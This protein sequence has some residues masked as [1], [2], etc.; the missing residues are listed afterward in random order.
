LFHA[1]ISHG[2]ASA[3]I[4]MTAKPKSRA[5][6]WWGALVR[7]LGLLARPVRRAQGEGGVVIEPYRGYGSRS[8]IFMIGRVF[9]QSA[10]EREAEPDDLAA[11]LR[12][13]GRRIRRRKVAR[14]D[15]SVRFSG[16][17]SRVRTDKDGYFRV[18]LTPSDPPD[19]DQ[20][21]HPVELEL[22]AE[23][24]V[25]ARGL[26]FIPPASCRFVVVSDIDD[27]VMYTGVANKLAMLW[28]LFVADAGSR[29][30]FPGVAALYRAFHTGVG[31][32]ER[33][34]ILY[35]SRAPWGIY[36]VL[37]TFFR[38]NAIP[39]GP[40]L[41]LREWGLSWRK[42]WPRRA[43]DHKRDLIE[44]MLALYPHLPFVLIGDSG[45]HD[46]EV[47][48]RIVEN[49]PGR[50]AAVYI[51]DVSRSADRSREVCD[52]AAVV[53]KDGTRLLLAAD[54][55]AIATH[56]AESGYIAAEAVSAVKAERR[57]AGDDAEPAPARR[58]RADEAQA[59]A[60]AGLVDEGD[61]PGS[62][63]VEPADRPA[64]PPSDGRS[65]TP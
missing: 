54:S 24:P 47:Y 1:I 4:V 53:A 20:D 33:N 44:R 49:H 12:D 21:W 16:T 64:S 50:V 52:L 28:R 7:V 23:P 38:A 62:V 31:G 48:A 41:F 61:R 17:E 58:V 5:T 18:H 51:R 6:G 56:A 22:E 10:P 13:I 42:P 9:R 15:L 46:P 3:R 39:V 34:P 11:H 57:E 35:V 32:E 14:A 65:T 30:A 2:P 43:R 8:E 25:V 27:T 55:T 19:A 63:I 59:G 36:D 45:Q 29:V 40:V 37:T 60:I 26:V